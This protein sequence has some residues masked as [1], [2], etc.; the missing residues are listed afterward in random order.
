MARLLWHVAPLDR[1]E[2]L[3]HAGQIAA[4]GRPSVEVVDADVPA[5]L[6]EIDSPPGTPASPALESA[7]DALTHGSWR[8]RAKGRPLGALLGELAGAGLAED[9][10][11]VTPDKRASLVV[12]RPREEGNLDAGRLDLEAVFI[13]GREPGL[14]R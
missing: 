6:L 3:A 10:P 2:A 14:V 8:S 11:L 12:L 5:S 9:D 7:L 4:P 13:D 1:A